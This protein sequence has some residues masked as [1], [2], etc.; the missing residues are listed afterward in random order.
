[1]ANAMTK[2]TTTAAAERELGEYQARRGIAQGLLYLVLTLGAIV[3]IFPF[4]WML[5]TAFKTYGE[6]SQK[7]FWPAALTPRPYADRPPAQEIDV[8][9]HPTDAWHGA[10]ASF[11]P[12]VEAIIP[13]NQVSQ[14]V[15]ERL[16]ER[17]VAI[18]FD[19]LILAIDT[20]DDG[21]QNYDRFM[22]TADSRTVEQFTTRIELGQWGGPDYA[23]A[24]R[25]RWGPHFGGRFAPRPS[26]DKA[27]VE[28]WAYDFR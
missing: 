5:L 24:D 11:S 12:L 27:G 8:D 16:E 15:A 23:G 13:I 18:P 17:E 10:T 19:V 26:G 21:V 3:A 2:K 25:G 9:L 6:H 22:L 20:T 7:V 1:M 4:A 14:L 28:Y